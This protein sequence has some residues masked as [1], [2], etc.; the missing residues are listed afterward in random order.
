M[1]K[2]IS[3][4]E[5][6]IGST[7]H[8]TPITK[9]LGVKKIVDVLD[10]NIGSKALIRTKNN[11][12]ESENRVVTETTAAVLVL[13]NAAAAADKEAIALTLKKIDGEIAGHETTGVRNFT[14]KDMIEVQA[15]PA[16]AN[17]SLVTMEHPHSSSLTTYVVDETVAAIL[18]DANA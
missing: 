11:R 2:L 15:D 4:T 13:Q 16:D 3:I 14:L 17:D 7:T 6:K 12:T 18:A 9:L 10:A 5:E 1:S 8:T